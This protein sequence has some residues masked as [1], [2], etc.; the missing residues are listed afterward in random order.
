MKQLKREGALKV[1]LGMSPLVCLDTEEKKHH[2]RAY[3]LIDFIFNRLDFFYNFK[4][5]Y[6]FKKKFDPNSW[7][8]EYL[9]ASTEVLGLTS[10]Y[11]LFRV[12]LPHGIT[13]ILSS[14]FT[15]GLNYF[16]PKNIFSKLFTNKIVL[17][18]V[19]HSFLEFFFR[20]K[21][22][23]TLIIADLLFFSVANKSDTH[24]HGRFIN[25]YSYQW[26]RLLENESTIKSFQ[27]L[28]IPS[29][30]HWDIIHLSTNLLFLTVF[31]GLLE[32]LIGSAL[33]STT[34]FL[35]VLLSNPVTSI[36]LI[37]FLHLISPQSVSSFENAIDVGSS[38]GIFS[39]IGILAYLSRYTKTFLGM[40]TIGVCII[41]FYQHD[42]LS[43]NHLTAIAIGLGL[44]HH[45]IP[46]ELT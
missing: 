12:L 8:P 5:L 24:L 34:Y 25:D 26:N 1:T 27:I 45:F 39:C 6:Q 20:I 44:A 38:L 9:I 22:T 41:S 40:I 13:S 2:P 31:V 32:M 33:V 23:L 35:G 10:Y 21:I 14:T 18:G 46:K 43:L 4:S 29:L 42:L 37:P 30:L 19:P 16:D 7:E 3:Q 17:R 28:T 15:N 11:S 36:L